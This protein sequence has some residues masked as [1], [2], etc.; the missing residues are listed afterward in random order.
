MSHIFDTPPKFFRVP[1]DDTFWFKQLKILC[2]RNSPTFK[3][4]T[5]V[6]LQMRNFFYRKF[7]SR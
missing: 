7:I 6:P 5:T 1:Q 2:S 4:F 3:D